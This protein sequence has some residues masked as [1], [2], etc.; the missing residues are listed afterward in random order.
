MESLA[1]P[2]S[3][4]DED[5]RAVVSADRRPRVL[6]R[7]SAGPDV[8]LLQRDLNVWYRLWG[9]PSSAMLDVDGF[10]GPKTERAYSRAAK[11]AGLDREGAGEWPLIPPRHRLVIRHLGR[12]LVARSEG[13]EYDVPA[14]ARRTPEEIERGVRARDFE[15][16][17]RARFARARAAEQAAEPVPE[18]VANV[19]NQSSRR[20]LRPRIIVLHTTEGH[21]R[22]G[23]SD[24]RGLVAFFDSPASQVSSH[25]A[26]D[27]DGNHARIVPD[28]AKAWTQRAFNAVALSIEQ[29]GFAGQ[30]SWPEAQLRNTALWIA[31]WS[32]RW[33]IPIVR[34]TRHGV[35]QH[36]DL[37]AAGGGHRDCGDGYPFERVLALARAFR[38]GAR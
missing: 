17:L 10:L 30:S 7:G 13:P 3:R 12:L 5:R 20:G 15:R 8:A 34:S 22:P 38:G 26:N 1:Q 18:I 16:R 6:S 23:L 9:A 29:I 25:V 33:G 2:A 21:N 24:L 36:V 27:A 19:R 35:C 11:R 37:G 31:H 4:S 32:R 28:E 14:S